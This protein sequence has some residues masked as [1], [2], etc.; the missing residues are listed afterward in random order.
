MKGKI[1]SVVLPLRSRMLSKTS[2]P[3]HHHGIRFFLL[4]VCLIGLCHMAAFAQVSWR[5]Y[6][7]DGK[8]QTPV[9]GARITLEPNGGSRRSDASGGFS[10]DSLADG[11]YTA[12]V[13]ATGFDTLSAQVVVAGG[14][15]PLQRLVLKATASGKGAVANQE[16]RGKSFNADG[17]VSATGQIKG[18]VFNA[19]DGEPVIF[20]PVFLKGAGVGAQTDVN[21]YFTLTK[22]KPG[23]YTLQVTSIGFDS[24]VEP[25]SIEA[26]DVITKRLSIKERSQITKT[27]EVVANVAQ[28]QRMSTTNISLTKV[29]PR[30]ILQMPSVGGEPDL[31]QYIQTIPGVVFTGD[32][33]GQLFIRG[34]SAVQNLTYLDGMMIYNPFHSIGLFSVFE[35][36]SIKNADIYTAGFGAEYGGR[37][38]SVMDVRTIDGNKKRW[39]VTEGLNP[40]A[41][42]LLVQAPLFSGEDEGSGGSAFFSVR[43]SLL[44]LTS[45]SLYNYANNGAGLPFSF[46]DLYGKVTL[47]SGGSKV[48]VQ[49]FRFDDQ[50][51]LG[52]L[53]GFGWTSSGLGTTFY[54]VPSTS[55]VLIS[56][57]VGYSDYKV[58]LLETTATPRTSSINNLNTQLDMT[59][60][61][62]KSE[63]KVGASFVVNGTDWTAISPSGQTMGRP[64]GNTEF[65][66][67]GKYKMAFENFILEPGLRFQYYISYGAPS[68]EPR[69]SAKWNATDKLRFKAGGGLYSQNLLATQ[70]DRDVVALFYGFV[71]SPEEVVDGRGVITRGATLQRAWHAVL[72]LEYDISPNFTINVEPYVKQFD[73]FISV[74]LNKRTAS[75]ADYIMEQGLARGVDFQI[76][77]DDRQLMMQLGYS[78]AEVSRTFGDT[79]YAPNYD[80]RHNLNFLAGYKFGPNKE[81]SVDVR[82]NY[83][84]GFPFTQT[85]GFYELMPNNSAANGNINNYNGSLGTYFGG[86]AE[87]NR[88][89]LPDY[90]RFDISVKRT[91]IL[92]DHSEMEINASV[93]NAYNRANLFYFDRINLERVNQLP[94]LPSIG[95]VLNL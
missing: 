37:A 85:Q 14:K 12:R 87:Y 10:F 62:N 63:V 26:G 34:G 59:Y 2:A 43:N 86:L 24:L 92:G 61:M 9:Q 11:S 47:A 1:V 7:I 22:I 67:F 52:N 44:N 50:A 53:A 77:Y 16:Q 51:A 79:T 73:P 95:L 28:E 6:V 54:L 13:A 30:E 38:S 29:T 91:F 75:N 71:T 81:W 48:S 5:G 46:L 3:I 20:T 40:F 56:G 25:I 72:G 32:Q 69:L 74:N 64:K 33:G 89:R 88:G 55:T 31:V 4:V 23:K 15:A 18:F 68:V 19:N 82:W 41:N 58:Q 80:R 76:K 78:L 66:V 45:K 42:R 39:Q 36:E 90:H 57:N 93:T 8:R 70:S 49:G 65:G 35:T 21:G 60:F 84:S 27:I 83:G 94:L 17:S